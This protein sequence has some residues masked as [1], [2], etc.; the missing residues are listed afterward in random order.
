[1]VTRKDLVIAVLVTFCL[2]ATLFFINTTRSMSTA[3]YD[4]SLDINHDGKI[5]MKDMAPVAKAYGTSGDPTVNVN[6]TNWEVDSYHKYDLN[7]VV[8][9]GNASEGNTE[10]V[11]FYIHNSYHG[12]GKIIYPFNVSNFYNYAV[13]GPL[14]DFP[15]S[16][17]LVYYVNATGTPNVYI[18]KFAAQPSIGYTWIHGT[19]IQIIGLVDPF[20]VYPPIYWGDE[21]VFYTIPS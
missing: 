16:H 11:T 1:M 21:M 6:V 9:I 14:G 19:Y 5:D 4:P 13:D 2:T 20:N 17:V 10:P 3:Q 7:I 12:Q 8:D 15:S 18:Y